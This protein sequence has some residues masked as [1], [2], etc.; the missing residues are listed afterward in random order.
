MMQQPIS[1]YFDNRIVRVDDQPFTATVLA[2]LRGVARNLLWRFWLETRSAAPLPSP[3]VRE[4]P[5][6]TAGAA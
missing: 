6:A 1:F 4:R 3:S 2:W 5:F